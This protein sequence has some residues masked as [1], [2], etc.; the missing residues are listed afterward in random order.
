M[1]ELSKFNAHNSISLQEVSALTAYGIQEVFY[2]LIEEVVGQTIE[3]ET[4]NMQNFDLDDEED[5]EDQS[6]SD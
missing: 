1:R 6:A 3:A 2:S 4:G 5:E